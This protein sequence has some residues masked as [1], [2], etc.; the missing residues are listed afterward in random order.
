MQ[1]AR[2]FCPVIPFIGSTIWLGE[3]LDRPLKT[4]YSL[5]GLR[6]MKIQM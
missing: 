2:I 6:N 4:K 5:P 1:E 3:S